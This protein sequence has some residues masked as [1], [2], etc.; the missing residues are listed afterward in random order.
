MGKTIIRYAL[1]YLFFS[2]VCFA[3]FW[4]ERQLGIVAL[5]IWLFLYMSYRYTSLGFLLLMSVIFDAFSFHPLGTTSFFLSIFLIIFDFIHRK[6][7]PKLIVWILSCVGCGIYVF[8]T[9]PM[10]HVP[11]L[12][13][14][15][16]S[17]LFYILFMFRIRIRDMFISSHAHF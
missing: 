15:V 12:G 2:C 14:V 11:L 10:H 7:I 17:S 5:T 8:L 4:V 3:A 6:H 1:Q 16:S 9:Q 13:F